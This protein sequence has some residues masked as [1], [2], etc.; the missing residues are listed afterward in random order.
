[1]MLLKAKAIILCVIVF[2]TG[3]FGV[4]LLS[5]D[6]GKEQFS[7]S[8]IEI[9]KKLA[10]DA[11]LE[12]PEVL[13]D[14]SR[15]LQAREEQIRNDN[16][17]NLVR[18]YSSELT[19][20]KD[21]VIIGN[22]S[23]DVT[24]VEFF[25]YNCPYCKTAAKDLQTLI[26]VDGNIKFIPREWPIL[27]NN[28]VIAAK[29]ALASV[30]QGKYKEF[31]W[32]LM[33]EGSLTESKIFDIAKNLG[34]N[35]SALK[36]NMESEFVVNHIAKTTALAR[37]IGFSGTPLFIIEGK[38]LPGYVPL[39]EL[40]KLISDIKQEI[41]IAKKFEY[42]TSLLIHMPSQCQTHVEPVRV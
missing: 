22:P 34:I 39:E 15:I 37:R 10:L 29:A 24:I 36:E 26:K 25:D 7:E 27:N 20:T 11:L 3:L 30:A 1:M 16:V 40:E 5:Q 38:V 31:H 4:P 17:S 28:S 18:E 21:T 13:R 42:I 41:S 6:K 8:E 35:I 9:I 2:L 14:A 19:D 23:G 32:G 33:K 12:N